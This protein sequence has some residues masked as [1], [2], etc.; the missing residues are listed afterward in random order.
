MEL[1]QVSSFSPSHPRP[2]G[3][4]GALT[5][6]D[7]NYGLGNIIFHHIG[8]THIAHHLFSKMPHVTF[9][10]PPHFQQPTL[11]LVST[12]PKKPRR[13]SEMC[14]ATSISSTTPPFTRHSGRTPRSVSPSRL[15][16]RASTGS[17]AV[18][19]C[20]VRRP[21]ENREFLKTLKSVFSIQ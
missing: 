19:S 20:L 6:V 3:D 1:A 10:P 18:S 15:M 2:S 14:W 4:R 21:N 16:R 17:S 11:F 5:T 9:P 12:T 7:R 13:R 8:D